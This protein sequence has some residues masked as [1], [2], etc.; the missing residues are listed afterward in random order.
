MTIPDLDA[1]AQA[2]VL[3]AR[4]VST[5]AAGAQVGMSG[6]QVRRWSEEPEFRADVEAARRAVLAESVA[7]LTAAVRDAVDT[8]HAALKDKS[9][10]IRLR[11][12]SE[13]VRALPLL[14]SHA[15]LEARVAALEATQT[16]GGA[17]VVR[18]A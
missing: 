11:A 9:P 5:D 7:A 2:V 17:H 8:L 15:E 12:A 13:I 1:K 16:P 10:S 4:G 3:L 6:R 14:A 18:V